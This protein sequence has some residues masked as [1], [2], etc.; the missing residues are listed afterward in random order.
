[1]QKS[2]PFIYISFC[3]NV[4]S[5]TELYICWVCIRLIEYIHSNCEITLSK[6][7]SYYFFYIL[8]GIRSLL[9]FFCFRISL[10][11]QYSLGFWYICTCMLKNMTYVHIYVRDHE[12]VTHIA[13]TQKIAVEMEKNMY[14]PRDISDHDN[15]IY[16][17]DVLST[18]RAGCLERIVFSF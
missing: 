5:S 7:Y 11:I 16:R 13:F 3:S 15:L 2:H 10:L 9:Y 17:K 4:I 8:Q 1:M 12:S 18:H 14:V 6:S